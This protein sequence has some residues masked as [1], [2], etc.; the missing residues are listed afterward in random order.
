MIKRVTALC[1]VMCMCVLG[2][3]S[4]LNEIKD[5][6][7]PAKDLSVEY[8][9]T[10]KDTSPHSETIGVVVTNNGEKAATDIEVMITPYDAD[11]NVITYKEGDP[12]MEN[13]G[14]PSANHTWMISTIMPGE[15]KA[16]CDYGFEDLKEAPDHIDAT[17]KTVKWKDPAKIPEGDV[18]VTDYSYVPGSDYAYVTLKN[19]TE[20]DYDVDDLLLLYMLNLE[21]IGYDSEGRIV[22]ADHGTVQYLA[23]GAEEG[24]ELYL[25]GTLAGTG[26]ETV[27]VFTS[28]DDFDP[29]VNATYY[30]MNGKEYTKEDVLKYLEEKKA[31]MG[32]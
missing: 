13:G 16:V 30:D 32:Q 7:D 17:I 23:A 8:G 25:D 10:V 20:Y 4:Q 21:F 2:G 3:C 6:I 27:E 31:G 14:T 1:L 19:T 18:T 26:A 9:W 28:R 22:G 24:V 11:G 12:G 5:K 15:K 29:D